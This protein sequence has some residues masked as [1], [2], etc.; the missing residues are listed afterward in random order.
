MVCSEGST[1]VSSTDSADILSCDMMKNTLSGWAWID[2]AWLT[3]STLNKNGSC[4]PNFSLV[5]APRLSGWAWI[6]STSC[7]LELLRTEGPLGCVPIH[8]SAYGM[9]SSITKS[10]FPLLLSKATSL[11]RPYLP[12][13]YCCIVHLSS[14]ICAHKW[15]G[16]KWN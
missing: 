6:Q 15:P 11:L 12:Q 16:S 2:K 13:A 14:M 8:N 9:A 10:G 1:E 7:W 3:D 4:N 5:L